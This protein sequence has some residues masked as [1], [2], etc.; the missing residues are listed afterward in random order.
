MCTGWNWAVGYFLWCCFSRLANLRGN[1]YVLAL[2]RG[3]GSGVSYKMLNDWSSFRSDRK[4]IKIFRYVCSYNGES[5]QYT[6]GDRSFLDANGYDKP[7]S[8]NI[9]CSK[10][11]SQHLKVTLILYASAPGYSLNVSRY[12]W[13]RGKEPRQKKLLRSTHAG[14]QTKWHTRRMSLE[15]DPPKYFDCWNMGPARFPFRP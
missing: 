15:E 1:L 7:L 4:R 11:I 12:R 13:E 14:T 5:G 10:H 2:R 8:N 9:T 6:Y 3:V